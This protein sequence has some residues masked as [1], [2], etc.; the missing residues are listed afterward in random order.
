LTF[1]EPVAVVHEPPA[2]TFISQFSHAG[3]GRRASV[4]EG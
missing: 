1:A 3:S 2:L 4:Y